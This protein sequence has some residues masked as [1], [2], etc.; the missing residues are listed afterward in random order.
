MTYVVTGVLQGALLGMCII[1][2]VR[3][4][5]GKKHMNVQSNGEERTLLLENETS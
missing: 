4:K 3:D 5:R 1:W 2:E